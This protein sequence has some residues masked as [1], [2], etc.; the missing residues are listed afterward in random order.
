MLLLAAVTVFMAYQIPKLTLSYDYVAAVPPS[1]SSMQ[2]YEDFKRQFGEDANLL[3]V[4]VQDSALYEVSTFRRFSYLSDAIKELNGVK[5]VV[6]LPGLQQLV[7]NPPN[8]A[9]RRGPGVC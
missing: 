8:P 6:S 2:Y 1:D 7:K 3:V 5:Y 4:G 9:L